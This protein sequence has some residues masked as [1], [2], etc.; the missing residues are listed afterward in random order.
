MCLADKTN[1][2]YIICLHRK[3][4]VLS[5]TFVFMA[6]EK[7]DVKSMRESLIGRDFCLSQETGIMLN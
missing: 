1:V 4:T 5:F 2:R 6:L 7:S 3:E